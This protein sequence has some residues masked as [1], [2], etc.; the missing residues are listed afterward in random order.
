[1]FIILQPVQE[2]NH[3]LIS[4]EHGSASWYEL[5]CIGL[6]RAQEHGHQPLV[7]ENH[8]QDGRFTGPMSVS[9]TICA[10]AGTGGNNLPL[11]AGTLAVRDCKGAGN[12]YAEQG[13]LVVKPPRLTRRLIPGDCELLPGY[14]LRWT[15]LPGASDSARYRALPSMPGK[16]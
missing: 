6:L 11:V 9:P 12:I 2:V 16:T 7:F 1:M 15:D 3:V 5:P 13:K 14:P 8:K 10:G 4:T